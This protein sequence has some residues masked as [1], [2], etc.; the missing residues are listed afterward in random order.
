MISNTENDLPHLQLGCMAV[1]SG[2]LAP[3]QVM[4]LKDA[5]RYRW[6]IFDVTKVWPHGD[7]PLIPVGKLVL[8]KN[9]E[10]YFQDVEQ[11]AFSPA[12]MVPGIEPSED[13]MLQGRLFSYSDTHRHRLGGKDE[14]RDADPRVPPVAFK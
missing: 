4:P 5:E 14:L 12:H 10:N 8:D 11:A 7:Y 1:A 13:R 6:N 3:S 2:E 9:P